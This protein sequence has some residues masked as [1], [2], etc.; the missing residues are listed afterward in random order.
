MQEIEIYVFR[1]AQRSLPQIMIPKGGNEAKTPTDNLVILLL[2]LLTYY[3]RH[4]W[5]QTNKQPIQSTLLAMKTHL[6]EN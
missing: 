3:L 6:K 2:S 1:A 4:K 5:K